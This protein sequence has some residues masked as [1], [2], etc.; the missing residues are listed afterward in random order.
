MKG[1]AGNKGAICMRFEYCN[2]GICIINTHLASQKSNL[3]NRNEQVKT[4]LKKTLFE[5]N[6]RHLKISEHDVVI[7]AGDLN[8]RLQGISTE[9][10]RDLVDNCNFKELLLY[11]QFLN[12]KI[13]EKI[14]CEFIEPTINFPPTYKYGKG[15]CVYE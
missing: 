11:D 7:W 9:I 4:I 13:H 14:L 1:Y 12:Q 2:T 5:I 6:E 3:K 8:Y 10:I 15:A